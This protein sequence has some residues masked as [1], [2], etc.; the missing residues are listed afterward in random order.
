MTRRAPIN[1][2]LRQQTPTKAIFLNEKSILVKSKRDR[3]N[4]IFFLEDETSSVFW[5]SAFH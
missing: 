4:Q 5:A 3:K 1:L 2:G